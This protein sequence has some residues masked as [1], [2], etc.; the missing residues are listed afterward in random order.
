MT[1]R[2]VLGMGTGRCGTRSLAAL[3]DQQAGS[4]VTHEQWPLLPWATSD[5]DA[6]IRE[7]LGRMRQQRTEPLIG[8][9][10]SFYLPYV[11]AAL[12]LDPAV[13]VVCLQRPREEVIRSFEAWLDKVHPLNT[14]HWSKTPAPGWHHEPVYTRIFPQYDTQNR[15]E[16]IGRY[17]DEYAQRAAALAEQYPDRVRVL[18][19]QQALNTAE[20]QRDLLGFVG[21]PPERQVVSLEN[22]KNESE[23]APHRRRQVAGSS[24]PMDP[25]RCVVLVPYGT[26]IVPMCENPLKELEKRGYE[27]RRVQGYAAIDQGRNQMSTDALLDGFEETLWIDSDMGFHPDDVD[28]IRRH[29][30]PVVTIIAPQKGK[31]ALAC[32]IMPGTKQ[33]TF[34]KGGGLHEVL[35]AGTGFLHVRREVY[36]TVQRKL[37]LPMCNEMFGRPMI[38]FFQPLIRRQF[39]GAWYLAE[40]YSFCHRARMCGYR[41]MA[42]TSIRIWHVGSYAY[43]WEDAGIDRE[44]FASFNY[45][46]SPDKPEGKGS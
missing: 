46:F 27:V 28:K 17:W 2:I 39:E 14:D 26:H 10:A 24:D 12:R 31:R 11:A 45:N 29:R 13:C 9:V 30:L 16:G 42:D 32:H 41:I 20:G 8:D 33:L 37:S 40:D 22:R 25:R 6:L 36:M 38:P 44:R 3:L 5:T 34:G 43:S 18:N 15:A 1:R 35:Y 19:M 7:R 4:R 23:T 21:I